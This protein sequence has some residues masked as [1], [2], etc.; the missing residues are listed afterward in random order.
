MSNILNDTQQSLAAALARL[1]IHRLRIERLKLENVHLRNVL[2]AHNINP[3]EESGEAAA[4]D[5]DAPAN[6]AGPARSAAQD[7][8]AEEP[9]QM[10]V[11]QAVERAE[12]K[13]DSDGLESHNV[14]LYSDAAKVRTTRRLFSI[15]SSPNKG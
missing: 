5:A 15:L 3:G 2:R 11:E 10:P 8:R 14:L 9:I 4:G 1:E 12:G 6:E 13:S 7:S